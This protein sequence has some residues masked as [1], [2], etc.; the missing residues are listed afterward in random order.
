MISEQ[1]EITTT[2]TTIAAL[3]NT[4]RSAT[5]NATKIVGIM[6]RYDITETAVV[7]LSDADSVAGAVVLD[8]ATEQLYSTSFRQFDTQKALLSCDTGTV[9]VHLIAEQVLGH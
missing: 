6:L 3:L 4:A 8:A 1:L 2:P 7:T 5:V 9:V